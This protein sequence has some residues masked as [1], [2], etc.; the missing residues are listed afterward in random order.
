MA[1]ISSR[2]S[3]FAIKKETTSGTPVA[4]S[5]ATDF[6]A[7]QDDF[8]MSPSIDVIENPELAGGIGAAAPILGAEKPT[9]TFSHTFRHSGTE[10]QEPDY[11][12]L[13]EGVLGSKTVNA[14]EYATTSLGTT[15]VANVAS[16]ANHYVGQALLIKDSTNGYKIRNV[17]AINTNALS[18]AFNV[19]AAVPNAIN[20]GKAISYI[21]V[22]SGH[23]SYS[24]WEY[25][26]NGGLTQLIAGAKLAGMVLTAD[27]SGLLNAK[28]DF[29]G[30][31]YYFDPI[32]ITAT[33]KYID[34]DNGSVQAVALDEKVYNSPIELAAAIEAKLD[35][36]GTF[37]VTYSSTTGKFTL[38][39]SAGTFSLLFATGANVANSISS[40]IGFTAVDAT[41]F[42]TYTS[43]ST[44]SFA[45]AYTANYDD[46]NP[47]VAK[48]GEVY[49]GSATDNSC[50]GAQKFTLNVANTISDIPDICEESGSAGKNIT[51]RTVTI[52]LTAT[53]SKYDAAKYDKFKNGTLTSF[54]FNCGEKLASNWVA[55]KCVNVYLPSC[56]ISNFQVDKADD[57][58]IFTMT[59]TAFMVDGASE[60]YINLV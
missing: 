37:T 47:L 41:G 39:K 26:G 32:V 55:G 57:V 51:G 24:L 18:L 56:K 59:L 27:P 42:L 54:M 43:Q 34:F 9:A 23:P 46:T 53:A 20:L 8:S 31:K 58:T 49:L 10:G 1:T 6:V 60:I 40:T 5:A 33:N 13:L 21:P 36:F 16:G 11:G 12:E 17:S 45:A 14:T 30:Q 25:E 3:V 28:Y 35:A 4:P 7:L 44:V 2:A 50:F 38:V 29:Q 22:N 19:S 48:N 52:E 15:S